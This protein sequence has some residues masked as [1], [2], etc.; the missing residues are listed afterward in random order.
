M[1]KKNVQKIL[2]EL[3]TGV[4][5][6][7][8]AKGRESEEILEAIKAGVK[9]VGENYIG[10]AKRVYKSIGKRVKWH[11]IGITKTENTIS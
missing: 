4:E 2:S 1:I 3:P 8:A 7:A 6:V 9:I 11:F 5:L 10:E